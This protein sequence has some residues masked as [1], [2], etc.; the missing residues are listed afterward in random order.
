MPEI[1]QHELSGTV[2]RPPRGRAQ[3]HLKHA[4]AAC[5]QR[6]DARR[7]A[8][9]GTDAPAVDAALVG[10]D[11]ASVPSLLEA[12]ADPGP[13]AYHGDA[14]N[15]FAAFTVSAI[16]ALVTPGREAS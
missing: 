4:V 2:P 5:D 12:L 11:P 10:T 7:M 16:N 15:R 6:L 3:R 13:L 9:P 8:T 14:R 1:D